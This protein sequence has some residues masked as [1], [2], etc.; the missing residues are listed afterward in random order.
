MTPD[1][2]ALSFDGMQ[3]CRRDEVSHCKSIMWGSLSIQRIT[4]AKTAPV[5]IANSRRY[6]TGKP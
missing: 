2:F 6:R 4:D 5:L 1:S 3:V